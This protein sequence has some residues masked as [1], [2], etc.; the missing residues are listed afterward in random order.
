MRW[1]QGWGPG[2]RKGAWATSGNY[3]AQ[4][5]P[6][7]MQKKKKQ[8]V[9]ETKA[10]ALFLLGTIKTASENEGE[11]PDSQQITGWCMAVPQVVSSSSFSDPQRELGAWRKES[12]LGL[13]WPLKDVMHGHYLS[14]N[15]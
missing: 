7:N 9:S 12:W 15:T 2:M 1:R 14:L 3:L 8:H 6:I 13:A 5:D 10:S 11:A 4:F